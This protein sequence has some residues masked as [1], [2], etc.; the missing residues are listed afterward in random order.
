MHFA[1][2]LRMRNVLAVV[3]SSL[4]CLTAN[5]Q[6][7]PTSGG[8]GMSGLPAMQPG[9]QM[10]PNLFPGVPSYGG[11][12]PPGVGAS[13]PSVGIPKIDFAKLT[14][15]IYK[16]AVDQMNGEMRKLIEQDFLK[17]IG[18]NGK[19]KVDAINNDIANAIARING[20]EQDVNNIDAL[21]QMQTSKSVC[22][23]MAFSM[24]MDTDKACET[25]NDIY[26]MY[27]PGNSEAS[28]STALMTIAKGLNSSFMDVEH[29]HNQNI[30]RIITRHEAGLS[31]SNPVG[32]YSADRFIS[33]NV[34]TFDNDQVK[35]FKDFMYII[36][37]P[38]YES[39]ETERSIEGQNVGAKSID[40]KHNRD[41]L[42]RALT[43][44]VFASS[45]MEKM[46]SKAGP[47]PLA[48]MREFAKTTY[49]P[50][51][52]EKLGNDKEM[53]PTQ[54]Y[55]KMVIMKAFKAHQMLMTYEH[56]LDSETL[57]ARSLI[58]TLEPRSKLN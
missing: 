49:S 2:F 33:S 4:V 48:T 38:V 34:S 16:N 28:K 7:T 10:G 37:P 14:E 53:T 20:G 47:S 44:S 11:N 26:D 52:V 30:K 24:S 39:L 27:G 22:K 40:M 51:N 36:M 3:V 32:Y 43:S 31:A 56:S 19:D 45:L 13:V 12:F 58:E 41:R 21:E 54:L 5:A 55:R 29:V 18:Q 1:K 17:M 46:P 57:A 35:D 42:D 25:M 15:T 9:F 23:D 8:G 50:E 6:L